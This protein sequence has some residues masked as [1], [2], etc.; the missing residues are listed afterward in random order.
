MGNRSCCFDD[1]KNNDEYTKDLKYY[2]KQHRA[3]KKEYDPDQYV[4]KVTPQERYYKQYYENSGSI[5]SPE[6]NQNAG[7]NGEKH[8]LDYIQ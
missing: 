8:K 2:T 1:M 5:I 7:T 4:N 3:E 6:Y